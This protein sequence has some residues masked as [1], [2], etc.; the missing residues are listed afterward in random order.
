[1]PNI[2]S[3]RIFFAPPP[4]FFAPLGVR[5]AV[6]EAGA[7]LLALSSWSLGEGWQIDPAASLLYRS[8]FARPLSA[9]SGFVLLPISFTP[10]AEL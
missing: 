2:F 8:S 9:S 5:R 10:E 4:F 7:V 6:R 1:M 3:S